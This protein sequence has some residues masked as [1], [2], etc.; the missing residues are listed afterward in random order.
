MH[1]MI[2]FWLILLIV[3]VVSE[4]LSLGLT[5]IWFAVGAAAAFIA[6]ALGAHLIVQIVL[7][8][9]AS[10][11]LL[12]LIRP[13]AQSKFNTKRARTNADSLIGKNGIV[14]EPISNL[15]AK[16]YIRVSGMDWAARSQEEAAEIEKGAEVTVLRIEGNKAIVRPVIKA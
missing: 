5:T 7:F 16:G 11:V 12:L 9:A 6:T 10:F 15:N 14:T 4:I 1:G 13:L 8:L 2:W 3:F